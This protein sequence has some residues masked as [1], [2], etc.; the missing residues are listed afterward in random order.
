MSEIFFSNNPNEWTRTEGV[1]VAIQKPDGGVVGESVNTVALVG[2]TTRGDALYQAN[3]PAQFLS[4]SGG[5]DAGGG[6]ACTNQAWKAMLN[7][8]F[9]WPL[10]V[11]PVKAA[12]AVDWAAVR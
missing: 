4:L 6:G 2:Q 8:Q 5:R 1:T 9:S 3:T 10:I 11:S 12:A 7:R